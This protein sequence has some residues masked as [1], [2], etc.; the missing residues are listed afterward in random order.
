[1]CS[2][3]TSKPLIDIAFGLSQLSGNAQLLNK[4]L[5]R[6]AAEYEHSSTSVGALLAQENYA[7]AKIQIH[8]AKGITGNLGLVALFEHCKILEV[9][10]KEEKVD[11]EVLQEYATLVHDTCAQIHKLEH[12]N[13]QS[14]N[15]TSATGN[16]NEASARLVEILNKQEFIDDTLLRELVDELAL[17]NNDKQTFIA[18]VEALNYEQALAMLPS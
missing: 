1:V 10:I 4:M 13:T 6:F 7:E 8:T 15:S 3:Q 16:K 12:S 18:L 14:V 2:L 9:Q 11:A 5:Q 17:S